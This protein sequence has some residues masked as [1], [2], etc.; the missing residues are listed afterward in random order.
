MKKRRTSVSTFLTNIGL[1]LVGVTLL[2]IS[3]ASLSGYLV[4]RP[5]K[6]GS[7]TPAF[8]TGDAVITVRKPLSTVKIGDVLAYTP[9]KT[10]SPVAHR[11]TSLEKTSEGMEVQTKGD[12]NPTPDAWSS[13]LKGSQHVVIGNMP[14]AGNAWF[15]AQT[16]KGLG[17]IISIFVFAILY[18]LARALFGLNRPHP[19]YKFSIAVPEDVPQGERYVA[20]NDEPAHSKTKVTT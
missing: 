6:S 1:G 3:I 16:P 10:I 12:A 5:V 19:R 8:N 7:M 9:D 15:W 13:I 11:I 14:G 17:I 20:Y 2:A 4:I 18:T